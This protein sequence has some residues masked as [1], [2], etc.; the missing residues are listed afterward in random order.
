VPAPK[1]ES[2]FAAGRQHAALHRQN[3]SKVV[4]EALEQHSKETS[5]E[6]SQVA[7]AARRMQR[8]HSF[9]ES[10]KALMANEFKEAHLEELPIGTGDAKVGIV[11]ADLQTLFASH[12]ER[13]F[14]CYLHYAKVELPP[15]TPDASARDHGLEPALLH[16]APACSPIIREQRP[17]MLS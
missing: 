12:F 6:K 17:R 1:P 3:T 5:D 16:C 15:D 13:L 8:V 11:S 7:A 10:L 4:F 14:D 9:S 2:T